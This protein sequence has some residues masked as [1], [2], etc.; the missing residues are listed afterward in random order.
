VRR[1]ALAYKVR[2]PVPTTTQLTIDFLRFGLPVNV[3]LPAKG[4]TVDVAAL[5]AHH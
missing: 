3:R 1:E 5:A 2:K 4:D